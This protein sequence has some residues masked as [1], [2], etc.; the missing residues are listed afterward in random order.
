MMY[1]MW[2]GLKS[3]INVNRDGS[4]WWKL[5]HQWMHGM[6]LDLSVLTCHS[7]EAGIYIWVDLQLL[8]YNWA[9]SSAVSTAA[10]LR[11]CN[12][13]VELT[14]VAS[15]KRRAD[16]TIIECVFQKA[17]TYGIQC[18]SSCWNG[19]LLLVSLDRRMSFSSI[20]FTDF[21]FRVT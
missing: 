19:R 16:I 1:G 2:Q 14:R 18:F 5:M 8:E 4:L 6:G 10:Y 15:K 7:D 9:E 12:Q 13:L 17:K 20:S 11:H 21:F 3:C